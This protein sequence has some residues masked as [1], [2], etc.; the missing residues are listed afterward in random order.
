MTQ[1]YK[2]KF[3]LNGKQYS[4]EVINGIAYIDGKT[5]SEFVKTL[6][7]VTLSEFAKVGRQA[8]IDEKNGTKPNSYQGMM[9][10]FHITKNN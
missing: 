1:K 8:L 4:C 3:K 7:S 6:D 5:V 10:G 9:D 2:G